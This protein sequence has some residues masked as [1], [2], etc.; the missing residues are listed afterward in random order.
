MK[1]IKDIILTGTLAST[2]IGFCGTDNTGLT[3][4][5]E[6]WN[7]VLVGTAGVLT[8]TS[9]VNGVAISDENEE[10]VAPENGSNLYLTIDSNIQKIAE[11]YLK[12]AVNKNAADYR[13]SNFNE[14]TK[15]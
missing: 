15:W 12:E 14:P 2:L 3:G 5:E 10:Y 11:K 7:D 4:L 13:W 9:D 8:V 6:R 1:I